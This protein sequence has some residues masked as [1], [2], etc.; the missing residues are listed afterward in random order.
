MKKQLITLFAVAL[1]ATVQAAS[2]NWSGSDIY[3]DWSDA[4][5]ENYAAGT[6]YLFIAG[7]NDVT[8]SDLSSA[9]SGGTFTSGGWASKAVSSTELGNNTG[10]FSGSYDSGATD[11]EGKSMYAVVLATGY[12]DG[13]S[14]TATG[15]DPA[16]IVMSGAQTAGAQP[17]LGSAL[18]RFGSFYDAGLGGPSGWT[19]VPEPC[20]VALLL[21]G[22]AA[23]G[24]KRKRA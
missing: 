7:V 18:V 20:S 11:Y 6:A 12:Y 5:S 8:E 14:S 15:V 2:Y 13:S 24:L 1:A 4:D 10:A 22:A 17:A 19:A 16:Y 23:F 21:F 9:I 3:Q